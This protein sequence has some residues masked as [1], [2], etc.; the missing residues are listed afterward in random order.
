[1]N[2]EERLQVSEAK[3]YISVQVEAESFYFFIENNKAVKIGDIVENARGKQ[4]RVTKINSKSRIVAEEV[5]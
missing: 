4:F 5:E 2:L 3:G 1:M